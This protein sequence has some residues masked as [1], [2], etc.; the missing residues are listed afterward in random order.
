MESSRIEVLAALETLKRGLSDGSLSSQQVLQEMASITSAVKQFQERLVIEQPELV[1][2]EARLNLELQKKRLVDI[3]ERLKGL[4]GCDP[5]L[6]FQ[7]SLLAPRGSYYMAQPLTA[8]CDEYKDKIKKSTTL[9]HNSRSFSL[10]EKSR[11]IEFLEN[12]TPVKE[13]VPDFQD[14]LAILLDDKLNTLLEIRNLE[15]MMIMD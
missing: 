4:F 3:N 9:I 14:Q 15:M 7:Q 13:K 12:W 1:L 6:C 8:T 10:M 2:A 11:L 5:T